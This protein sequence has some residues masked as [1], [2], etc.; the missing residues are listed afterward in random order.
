M[1]LLAGEAECAG[2]TGRKYPNCIVVS[3][4]GSA[5]GVEMG[6]GRAMSG[7]QTALT[8]VEVERREGQ[9]EVIDGRDRLC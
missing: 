4:G 5:S 7:E 9:S 1:H 6:V 3:E 8:I 2:L